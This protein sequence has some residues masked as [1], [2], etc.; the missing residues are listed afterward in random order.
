MKIGIFGGSFDPI[1]IGHLFIANYSAEKLNLDK[2]FFVPAKVSP[3]KRH[4]K[5]LFSDDQRLEIL[6]ASISDNPKFEVSDFEIKKGKISYTFITVEF[7]KRNFQNSNLYL[8]IGEDN[9][10]SFTKWKNWKEIISEVTIICYPRLVINN[11]LKSKVSLEE[12]ENYRSRIV[13]LEEAPVIDISSSFIRQ[14]I[15]SGRSIRY[16]VHEKAL[17]LIEEYTIK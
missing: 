12:L 10:I 4:R 17:K 8:L 13:F 6:K 11:K 1:H 2:V 7:F 3:F 16:L 14:T 9:L 5:Y 15:K